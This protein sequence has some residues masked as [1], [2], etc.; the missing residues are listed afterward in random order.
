MSE[1]I[2]ARRRWGGARGP[3]AARAPGKPDS[4]QPAPT[5]SGWL[6]DRVSTLKL[7][8]IGALYINA[9]LGTAAVQSGTVFG[10]AETRVTTG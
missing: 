4:G 10:Q 8:A 3:T 6:S 1:E 9:F 2:S 7:N 5:A